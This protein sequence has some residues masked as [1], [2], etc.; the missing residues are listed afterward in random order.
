ML[1]RLIY[2]AIIM[3]VLLA[4]GFALDFLSKEQGTIEI[5]YGDK[6]WDYTLFEA[7]LILVAGI[8]LLMAAVWVVKFVIALVRFIFLDD[9]AFDGFLGRR[10]ERLGLDALAKGMVALEIGDG[11][12]AYKKFK[13][14][15]HKLGR[16]ELT[17][18]MNAKAADMAGDRDRAETY[19]KALASEASTA[20]VG[21]SGMLTH[22]L[23]NDKP[24]RALKLA[25]KA[26]ELAPKDAGTMDTLFTLQSQKFDWAG[27]RKTLTAQRKAKALPKPEADRREG[28][29][30]L[31]Q[32]LDAEE[33]GEIEHARSLAVEAAKLD[34]GNTEAVT[35]AVRHLVD[36][37][38]KRTASKLIQDSWRIEPRA[39]LAAAYATI[40]PDEAPAARRRRFD[41]LFSLKPDH[42]ETRFLQAEL[43]L[44]AEDWTGARKSIEALKETEPSARSCAIFAAIARGEGE[45]DH[46]VRGWLARAL[47]APRNADSDTEISH[48]AM[49]PLLI[50]PSSQGDTDEIVV[51]ED[52]A[53]PDT[54][55]TPANSVTEPASEDDANADDVQ[56]QS[57]DEAPKPAAAG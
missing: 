36:S 9:K 38:S 27:A 56:I 35:T 5:V 1:G 54:E 45:S 34:P 30:A 52:A 31:A 32:A 10:R 26:H 2:V 40:E 53:Q 19:Y 4:G 48:A 3:A 41:D 13:R 18:L 14:A 20:F 21:V 29:L 49:L 43:A 24:D 50:E 55:A 33:A 47:G 17:R 39:R 42:P 22:A 12:A 23:E 6:V 8:I 11:K 44:V 28:G 15:E 51:A 16:P 25:S 46:I 7:S 57:D 37:G